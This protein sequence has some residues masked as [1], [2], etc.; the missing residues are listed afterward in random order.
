MNENFN[1]KNF[2]LL[3]NSIRLVCKFE[4]E[5]ES[6]VKSLNLKITKKFS[7]K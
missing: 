2:N 3:K 7:L 4:G 6:E 1:N 5:F